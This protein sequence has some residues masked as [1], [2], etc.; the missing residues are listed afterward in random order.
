MPA[1]E[2]MAVRVPVPD[3]V[4]ASETVPTTGTNSPFSIPES[5]PSVANSGVG[6]SKDI[7]CSSLTSKVV[8][9]IERV[10]V[11]VAVEDI[12][13]DKETVPTGRFSLISIR[14]VSS[15]KKK[16]ELRL[17]DFEIKEGDMLVLEEWNPNTKEYTGRI[18]EKKVTYVAK[19]KIDKLFW[20]EEQ[21]KEKGIQIISLE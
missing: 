21:V 8:P 11:I 18:I 16:F 14:T 5:A 12:D 10:E 17:D 19:F 4:D 3:R 20:P 9:A 6:I 1:I 7:L 13:T 2:R 15:G